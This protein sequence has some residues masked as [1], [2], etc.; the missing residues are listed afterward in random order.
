LGNAHWIE[1]NQKN[2]DQRVSHRHAQART[3]RCHY[4]FSRLVLAHPP[5]GKATFM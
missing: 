2:L 3:N 5:P 1:V 4:N